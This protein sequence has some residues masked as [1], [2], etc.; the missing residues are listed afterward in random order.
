MSQA[1]HEFY[2]EESKYLALPGTPPNWKMLICSREIAK[3]NVELA[4]QL[5]AK[6]KD[7]KE[8][9]TMIGILSGC[10][11][12]ASDLGRLLE[13]NLTT[14]FLRVSSYSGQEQGQMK[15][16]ELG[17]VSGTV[18]LIDELVDSG[19]TFTTLT[20]LLRQN[21]NVTEIYT[22]AMFSKTH[23][24]V[25]D[26]CGF[27]GIPELW[28]VGYGLDDNGT[29]RNWPV[30]FAC[31]KADGVPKV[32][33]DIIFEPLDYP[34]ENVILMD[35]RLKLNGDGYGFRPAEGMFLGHYT[36]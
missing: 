11:M 36:N 30:L 3:K 22:C 18:I 29:K 2:N 17:K 15:M 34:G 33:E 9:I 25:P 13:F 8:P 7:W 35:L 6:F 4:A 23:S 31:P 10:Y 5:N 24:P 21:S 32:K 28:V 12:F 20:T 26:F 27:P 14:Q 19:K 16:E 1:K